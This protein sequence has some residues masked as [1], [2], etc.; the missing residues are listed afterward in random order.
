[1]NL[2]IEIIHQSVQ[3]PK[4]NL[5]NIMFKHKNNKKYINIRNIRTR[6]H[7]APVFKTM[8]PNIERCKNNVFYCGAVKRNNLSVNVRNT[9]TYEHVKCIQKKWS[10]QQPYD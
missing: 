6:L 7:D 5:L 8:K 4:L 2:P 3:L 9:E 10:L 1:M